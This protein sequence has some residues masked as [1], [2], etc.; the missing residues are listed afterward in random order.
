MTFSIVIPTYNGATFVEQAILSALAQTR[1][2]DEILISDDNSSD[3]TI[4]VCEKYKDKI[5]IHRNPQG[6]SG[7]VNGWNNAIAKATGAYI[8]IL[9]QDDLLSSTFLEEA[10]KA[11]AQNPQIKHLFAP[12]NY[13]DGD[14][15]ILRAPD[16]C[17]GTTRI[18]TG[19][20]YVRAYQTVGKPHIHRCP[21]VISHRD[22]LAASPYRA[23]AGHIADDDFFYRAGQY[24]DVIG[25]LKPLAS[26]RLHEQSE[27][28]HLKNDQL[29]SRLAHDYIYQ[30]A[31]WKDNDFMAGEAYA[32]FS[33]WAKHYA[34]NEYLFGMQHRN[35]EL[36]NKG[37]RDMDMVQK[38]G[39]KFP[40]KIRL[41]RSLTSFIRFDP[42][43][44]GI[45]QTMRSL[46]VRIV[47]I[48]AILRG[49]VT[50]L[51]DKVLI[52]APHPDDE[53]LGCGG[54]IQR[55]LAAGKEV[56]VVILTGGEAS[57]TACCGISA[58]KVIEARRKLTMQAAAILGL[59]EEFLHSLR[60][61]D[62]GIA[63]NH[64]QVEALTDLLNAI[65]PDA[66]F[67]PHAGEGWSDHVQ[68]G[69]I[70]TTLLADRP[71]VDLYAY[72]VWFWYYNVWKI[73]WT[74][75]L[76]LKMSPQEHRRK[77][78]AIAAYVSPKAPCGT[79]WSGNL[80]SVFVHA[81]Q[82]RNELYFKLSK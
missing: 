71:N 31:Q 38:L 62:G 1:P 61:P 23:E 76:K 66:V 73:D 28:G 65:A 47:R 2:A 44:K 7:F 42:I 46:R 16:Y 22:L 75:A 3:S 81:N 40:F 17:D 12:C 24:T 56:H 4:Q 50:P 45:F 35:I 18:Y 30:L 74:N 70:V 64:P 20:E 49:G 14:G 34:F 69:K 59:R 53:V 11:L 52:V 10:E 27:T 13:I 15:N 67:V 37:L 19:R 39:V 77:L 32:Y 29:V 78:E 63:A 72:C 6:P 60:F 41:F 48:L 80:P 5:K 26:Y 8:A 25:I 57:H 82:W 54:L 79:P 55:L 68:A 9:H 21:G 51:A 33:H 36:R 43:R 58:E